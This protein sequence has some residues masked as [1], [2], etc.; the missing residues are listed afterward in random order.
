[1]LKYVCSVCGYVH[2]EKVVPASC[3]LCGTDLSVRR[4]GHRI[5]GRCW[6]EVYS[7]SSAERLEIE[8]IFRSKAVFRSGTEDSYAYEWEAH[9]HVNIGNKHF[10]MF[11]T[12][13]L[14]VTKLRV[15]LYN[16]EEG[17]RYVDVLEEIPIPVGVTAR[18][19]PQSYKD[20]MQ[21]LF[22]GVTLLPA[23]YQTP[24]KLK[25]EQLFKK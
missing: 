3:P 23:G 18:L 15:W 2:E 12:N 7:L 14:N 6:R 17:G 22:P 16:P 13:E 25:K 1:M 11:V 4:R 24:I 10:Q 8:K 5:F 21:S 9:A 20:W 19:H